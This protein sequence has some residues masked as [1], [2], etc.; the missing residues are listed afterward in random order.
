MQFN[1]RRDYAQ[2]FLP[3]NLSIKS[4]IDKVMANSL[5]QALEYYRDGSRAAGRK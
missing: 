2:Y 1:L 5:E 4:F 3:P